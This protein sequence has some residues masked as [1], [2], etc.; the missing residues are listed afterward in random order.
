MGLDGFEQG[1]ATSTAGP[2]VKDGSGEAPAAACSAAS[3]PHS[4][5]LKEKRKSSHLTWPKTSARYQ[6]PTGGEI[7]RRLLPNLCPALQAL[8]TCSS[9]HGAIIPLPNQ[10]SGIGLCHFS[11]LFTVLAAVAEL[12]ANSCVGIGCH[13]SR[14]GGKNSNKECGCNCRPDGDAQYFLL[15]LDQL[16]TEMIDESIYGMKCA[17]HIIG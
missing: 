2:F 16:D 14:C 17:L 6:W 10:V 5:T 3:P 1:P 12:P 4:S 15:L 8:P 11:R 9:R 7:E 13:K